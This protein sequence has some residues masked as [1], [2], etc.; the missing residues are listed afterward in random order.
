[1]LQYSSAKRSRISRSIAE[2]M[3]SSSSSAPEPAPAG[4]V[5]AQDDEGDVVVVF[6]AMLGME[7]WLWSKLEPGN[8]LVCFI[9]ESVM[10][11]GVWLVFDPVWTDNW[12]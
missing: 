5:S 7:L 2:R 12:K 4:A 1:M 8:G 11:D 10:M 6:A 3:S 9:P